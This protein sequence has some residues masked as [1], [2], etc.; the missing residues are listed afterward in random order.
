MT[1]PARIALALAT[2]L[3]IA[4]AGGSARAQDTFPLL[5]PGQVQTR[6]THFATHGNDLAAIYESE[7]QAL[8]SARSLAVK[9]NDGPVI[10]VHA[11]SGYA[12]RSPVD[13]DVQF[14]P[15]DG[16]AVDM[17]SIRIDYRLGPIWTNVT[18][19]LARHSSVAGTRLTASGAELPSGDHLV[20]LRIRD[21]ANRETVAL[22][23]FTVAE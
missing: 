16:V 20:R 13:F 14:Q 3:M 9:R 23:S 2:S 15:R 12:L 8:G 6:T 5:A 21:A 18:R 17:T 22:I 7:M 19:K 11:P 10:M 1:A 4:P